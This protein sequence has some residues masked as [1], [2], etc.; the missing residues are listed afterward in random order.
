[1]EN[2]IRLYPFPVQGRIRVE[3]GKKHPG[4]VRLAPNRANKQQRVGNQCAPAHL[5]LPACRLWHLKAQVEGPAEPGTPGSGK[6]CRMAAACMSGI[7][8]ARVEGLSV[9]LEGFLR[10][11]CLEAKP[12]M[13]P[14]RRHRNCTGAYMWL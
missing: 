7:A 3:P 11:H 10:Q 4:K 14:G 2:R 8:A 9:P 5:E 13:H 12:D 6:D 1:M